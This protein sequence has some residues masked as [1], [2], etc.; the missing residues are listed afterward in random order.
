MGAL[1]MNVAELR[2]EL[3]KFE[4]R[5]RQK[6]ARCDIEFAGAGDF[7]G[8]RCITIARLQDE[9]G[10]CIGVFITRSP[11]LRLDSSIVYDTPQRQEQ[12]PVLIRAA[13]VAI[14]DKCITAVPSA[15]THGL[16]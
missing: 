11:G 4:M 10:K 1:T 12:L 9:P 8:A 7:V 15:T 2:E 13:F 5:L 14:R 6:Y 3:E 16:N